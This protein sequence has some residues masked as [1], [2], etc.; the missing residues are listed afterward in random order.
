VHPSVTSPRPPRFLHYNQHVTQRSP[1]PSRPVSPEVAELTR[2]RNE[3]PDLAP[4][5]DLQLDLIGLHRRVQG[6]VPLPSLRLDS[7][8]A[9]EAT[10]AGR[11]LLRFDQIPF[12]YSDVRYLIRETAA[13]MRRHDSLDEPDFKHADALARDPAPLDPILERWFNGA[14][15]KT[16]AQRQ[17][18]ALPPA[19][20][21]VLTHAMRPFLVR[22]AEAMLASADLSAWSA[23]YCPVCGGEPDFS[24]ITPNAERH[25][26]CSRCT[27]RWK[28][29]PLACPYCS[30]ADRKRITSFA[31]RDGAYRIYGCDVCKRYLKAYDGRRA[32]RP[33][34]VSVDS[35]ATIPL[36]AAAVQRGYR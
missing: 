18:E 4:A 15:V 10:L 36:D 29:D 25:L 28:F 17:V 26:I 24:T 27:A 14:A 33:V 21:Y 20:E 6:R 7:A 34:M 35:V 2:I 22:C 13:A 30:N 1:G 11:P 8:E 32:T 31:S 3:Q 23:P 12:E 9:R 19:L 5:V 16:E